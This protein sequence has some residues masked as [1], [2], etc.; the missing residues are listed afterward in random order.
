MPDFTLLMHDDSVREPSAGI[1]DRY[2]ASL[3]QR[4]G[5]SGGRGRQPSRRLY[6]Y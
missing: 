3:R 5:F 6:P 2:F 1:W 4:G